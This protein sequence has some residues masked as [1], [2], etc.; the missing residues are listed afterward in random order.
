MSHSVRTIG[1]FFALCLGLA[2]PLATAQAELALPYELGE[3]V[4][5]ERKVKAMVGPSVQV[6]EQGDIALAWTEED[7][8]VRSVLFARSIAPGG[9]MGQPV[10]INRAEES[11]YWRQEAPAMVVQ[12]KDVFVTWGLTH[13]KATPQQPFAT[14]LRLS[15]SID[16]G[17]TFQPSLLV[18]DD[19]GVIQHTFDA[20]HRDREGRLHLSWI[21]GRDGKKEPGT[22][23]ARSLDRGR[24]VTKNFKVDDGTCVCCRTA[25]TSGQDGM[26]YVAWRK[27]FEGNV[28]ETVVARSTDQ[29][30]TFEAPVIVGHDQWVFP[31]CPHRPASMGVDRQGRLYIVWYTEGTD[32][33]PAVYLAH[34]DDRGKSFS[35]KR[36]L[37]VAK[38]TFPDH[39]QIAVDPDGRIVVLWEEQGPVKRDVVMSVSADRGETFTRPHKLNEKKSQ[40]PVVAVNEQGLFALAWMEHGMPGLKIVTQRLR[41]PR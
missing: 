29:G 37:N 24:T 38:A 32:E 11:P 41:I 3:K 21:D 35:P 14:E 27:I 33:I 6:G 26:V 4:V 2:G 36:K 18:N 39:P 20:L 25:V 31:A 28:R 34:S 10:R 7:K 1:G 30:E 17:Q 23:V 19:P 16:G 13:P 40:T 5:T 9:P 15:R 22:Y 12:G 8:D